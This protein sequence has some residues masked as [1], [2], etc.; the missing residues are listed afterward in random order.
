MLANTIH[1]SPSKSFMKSKFIALSLFLFLLSF[2]RSVHAQKSKPVNTSQK[3]YRTSFK[4]TKTE[5]E[6]LISKKEKDEIK[7][8]NN[9]FITNST[10]LLNVLNGDTKFIRL[11]LSYFSSAYLT[12]QINGAYSTQVFILSDDK[13]V[14]YKG[15][16]QNGGFLM[17][18]CNRDDIVSE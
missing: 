17:T 8:K 5:F 7:F 3:Q 10:I 6:T 1:H 12:I 11:K 16:P 4:I 18:K 9:K 13:S 15:Q 2:N 14:F